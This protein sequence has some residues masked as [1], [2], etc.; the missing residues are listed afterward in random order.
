MNIH[1]FEAVNIN[2]SVTYHTFDS[3]RCKYMIIKKF[4]LYR[5]L[6]HIDVRYQENYVQTLVLTNFLPSLEVGEKIV[7]TKIMSIEY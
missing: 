3:F 5:I 2:A 7:K 1:V 6:H 4:Y